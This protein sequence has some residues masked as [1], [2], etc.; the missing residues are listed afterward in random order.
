MNKVLVHDI[1]CM[2]LEAIPGGGSQSQES[3][4]GYSIC[5]GH[6]VQA[7]MPREQTHE[8]REKGA[9]AGGC[10]F[11]AGKVTVSTLHCCDALEL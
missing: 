1:A 9:A 7:G 3:L 5:V 8:G 2:K 6:G 10:G 11:P 4:L